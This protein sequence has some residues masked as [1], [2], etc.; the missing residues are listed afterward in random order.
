[1]ICGF[2]YRAFTGRSSQWPK[3]R[4][5]HLAANPRCVHC[6]QVA[7]AVHHVRPFHVAKGLELDPTNFASVCDR[8]H[9]AVGHLGNFKLWNELFW[10]CV[11][12]ANRGRRGPVG[13]AE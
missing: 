6:L 3:A 4:K 11:Q 13:K 5:A 2:V 8:C 9:L 1:M 7:E 12:T 10:Q